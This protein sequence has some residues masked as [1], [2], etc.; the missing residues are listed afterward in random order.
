VYGPYLIIR[1]DKSLE[2]I[3]NRLR[4]M[5][6]RVLEVIVYET[7]VQENLGQ[8]LEEVGRQLVSGGESG[9]DLANGHGGVEAWLG[10]FSPSSAGMVLP[11]LRKLRHL[12]GQLPT[13]HA[14]DGSEA[15]AIG[16]ST[17]ERKAERN[18][19]LRVFAIGESTGA[20]LWEQR[21]PVEVVAREPTAE[22]VV[23]ALRG[24]P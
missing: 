11:H 17:A 24:C 19:G 13:K 14:S 12:Y 16:A 20:Y 1:G 15:A 4:E 7:A 3:S 9:D 8:D 6:R 5:G 21:L 2:E 18:R 22:G 23:Q 10:F